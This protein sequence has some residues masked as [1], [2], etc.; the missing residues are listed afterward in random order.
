MQWFGTA[1]AVSGVMHPLAR[2]SL[3][4]PEIDTWG[5]GAEM[6][7]DSTNLDSRLRRIRLL[8]TDCD[9]VL[10]DGRIWL[11]ADDDEQKAFHARDGQGISVWHRAGLQSGII[12]G[13]T[14]RAVAR[15]AQ[16]SKIHYVRQYAKDKIAAL[17]E[18][19]ADADVALDACCYIGDDLGD[20][21]VMRLVGFAAAV[22]D[23]AAD[24]KKA[25]HY[26][27]R[28]PGGAG[29]VR[30]VIEVILKAQGRWDELVEQVARR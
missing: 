11:T 8:L 19:V 27:T 16:E 7:S 10:T 30:E 21:G 12:S 26:I 28:L 17:H 4:P 15:R 18:I 3:N 25:A 5:F 20:I 29:A 2:S 9:G 23:A 24:T 1:S 14:S 6:D 13:R 22:A